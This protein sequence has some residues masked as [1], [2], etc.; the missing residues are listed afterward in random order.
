MALQQRSGW[1][2]NY[3]TKTRLA[4]CDNEQSMYYLMS[5]AITNDDFPVIYASVDDTLN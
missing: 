1:Q 5:M 4:V 3:S 2:I